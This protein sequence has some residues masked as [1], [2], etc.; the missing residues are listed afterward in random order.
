MGGIYVSDLTKP[1]VSKFHG[2]HAINDVGVCGHVIFL[3]LGLWGLMH[4]SLS[5]PFLFA[6]GIKEDYMFYPFPFP[7]SIGG[8]KKKQGKLHVVI[9][10]PHLL[11]FTCKF[12]SS[13]NFT[14]EAKY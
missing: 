1:G 13:V 11:L 5:G 8:K 3:S 4:K 14:K 9:C 2:L 6:I 10:W 12:S 7:L